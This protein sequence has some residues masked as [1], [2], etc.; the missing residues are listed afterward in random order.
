MPD[1][2]RSNPN[3]P[4]VLWN[5]MVAG[6]LP[7]PFT[8]AIWYQG[9]SNRGRAVQYAELFPAMVRDWRTAIGT[10]LPFVFVQIAPYGYGGD[11][12]ELFALRLAQ[13]KALALPRVGMAVT[14]DVGDVGDIHPRDKRTVGQ[15][16]AMQA[17]HLHYGEPA[18][19]LLPPRVRRAVADGTTVRLEVD[20]ATA[21][22]AGDHGQQPF[23][24]AGS[25]GVFHP[26]TLR[27]E[28]AVL[29]LVADG[30][31]EPKHVRHAFA[32][33][34]MASLVDQRGQPLPPFAL[35]V[36]RSGS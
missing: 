20:H 36:G 11:T 33:T 35:E 10:D 23:E 17:R 26:A 28:G 25:D 34:A 6:L 27:V 3:V 13:E 18:Q 21:W 16:L 31:A 12:G 15:R 8:G 4:T 5:G 32:A 30:V 7:F 9:E 2:L 14:T 24:L 29:V 22:S 19:D 1:S